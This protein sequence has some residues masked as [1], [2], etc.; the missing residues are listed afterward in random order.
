MNLPSRCTIID[1]PRTSARFVRLPNG[2]LLPNQDLTPLE[3]HDLD[4]AGLIAHFWRWE[5]RQPPHAL[6]T[7]GLLGVR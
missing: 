6:R 4:D 3:Y 7:Y 2:H 1:H 5:S